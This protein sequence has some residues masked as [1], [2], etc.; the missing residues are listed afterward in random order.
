MKLKNLFQVVQCRFQNFSQIFLKNLSQIYY[1]ELDFSLLQG[2][3][4]SNLIF[5]ICLQFIRYRLPQC[6]GNSIYL[7]PFSYFKNTVYR[8]FQ[9]HDAFTKFGH[10]LFLFSFIDP[11]TKL[12]N[13]SIYIVKNFLKSH[14]FQETAANS[15]IYCQTNRADKLLLNVFGEKTNK[16]H[17]P[18]DT[19]KNARGQAL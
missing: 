4:I 7:E 17:G 5:S 8:R 15:K 10:F 12:S 18:K 14:K 19:R 16:S 1:K 13:V 6:A 9:L 2:F 11:I 3:L